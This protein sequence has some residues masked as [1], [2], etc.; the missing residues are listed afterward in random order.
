MEPRAD[1]TCGPAAQVRTDG[2]PDRR[3]GRLQATAP[4]PAGIEMVR[5]LP[6]V[7][8]DP[9]EFLRSVRRAYGPVVQFP[10]PKPPVFLVDGPHLAQQVLQACSGTFDKDTVQYRALSLVTGEGLLAATNGPWRTQRPVVQPAFHKTVMDRLAADVVR[11]AHRM[12]ERWQ[13][14][15]AGSVVDVEAAMMRLGLEVVGEHLFDADLRATAPKLAAATMDALDAVIAQARLPWA[16]F[17]GLP[18]PVRHRY[19]RA[20][21]ELDAA[22]AELVD[23]RARGGRREDLL[24]LLLAAYPDEP[25]I[26]RDQIITFLVAGHET[27]ASALTW[28]C[29]LLAHHP[30]EQE[31]LTA[32]AHAVLGE[33]DPAFADHDL[34]PVARA[35]FD[36][37]LRLYPPAWVITRSTPVDT[38]LGNRAIPAGSMVIVCPWLIHRDPQRWPLPDAFLPQRFERDRPGAVARRATTKGEYLPFGTGPRL[39]IGRDFALVEAALVLAMTARRFRFTPLAR[40][41]PGVDALVTLRPSGGLLL[42][43]EPATGAA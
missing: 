17:R 40:R 25:R 21:A 32:E 24:G 10:M 13:G 27:V 4:G 26:V 6:Q 23:R 12:L 15:P 7:G 35:V 29:G 38:V 42:R 43:I 28:S 34:L 36:E 8:E 9:L 16:V 30:Q 3:Y 5:A 1:S 33:R 31:R 41:L 37:T 18:S 14:A 11:A 22:V 20:M 39:C 2:V 19:R